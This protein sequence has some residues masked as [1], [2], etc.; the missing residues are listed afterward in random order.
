TP[1]D[2]L[3]PRRQ[4]TAGQHIEHH[5]RA[6]ARRNV[7][8]AVLTQEGLQPHQPRV[9]KGQRRLTNRCELPGIELQITYHTVAGCQQGGAGEIEACLLERGQR[10]ADLRIVGALWT[11]LLARLL[12]RG[13]RTLYLR[14]CLV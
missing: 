6:C 11:E 13:L 12:Q 1:A 14:L 10:L 2:A 9:E 8:Q 5:L 4:H 7:L 3:Y